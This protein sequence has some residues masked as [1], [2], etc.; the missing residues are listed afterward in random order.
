MTLKRTHKREEI[1]MFKML[2]KILVWIVK[3]DMKL[4][5]PE[6]SNPV[7]VDWDEA[8]FQQHHQLLINRFHRVWEVDWEL[9]H[10]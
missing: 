4:I 10:L 6:N 8:E 5:V 1:Y 9:H 7:E 2:E 3:N